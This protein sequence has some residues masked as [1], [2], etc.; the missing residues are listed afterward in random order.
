MLAHT[1]TARWQ[2][3][4]KAMIIGMS[5]DNLCQFNWIN[6]GFTGWLIEHYFK[7]LLAFNFLSAPSAAPALACR[8]TASAG[9]RLSAGRPPRITRELLHEWPFLLD[10]SP[11]DF[12]RKASLMETGWA[13]L[14]PRTFRPK[15]W[16]SKVSLS[17][18]RLHTVKLLFSERWSLYSSRI[19]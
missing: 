16:D 12:R 4:L 17:P 19:N 13:A 10:V 11:C 15:V 18:D 2:I 6:S 1:H 14:D 5:K 3:V 8:L 7:L 9:N